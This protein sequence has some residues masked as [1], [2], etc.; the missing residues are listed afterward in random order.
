MNIKWLMFDADNTLLDFKKACDEGLRK[1]FEDFDD[2]CTPEIAVLY[3]KINAEVWHDFE[4]GMIDA[5][6]LRSLRFERLFEAIETRPADPYRF[7][8]RYLENLVFLSEPYD[9]LVAFL[10]ALKPN[11]RISLITNGLKE[12]QRPRLSRLG[13]NHHFDSIV[14]SDEIGVAK[15]DA[16][17]FEYAYRDIPHEIEKN[18]VMVVGDNIKADIGGGKDYGFKTCW[19]HHGKENLTEI[20]PDFMIHGIHEFD[21][22]LPSI[23]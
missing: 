6:E 21:R 11:Y 12:V 15:P 17:F 19:V 5:H 9:G 14:V 22:V 8:A 23:S 13:L 3:E 7:N 1:T 4:S 20:E 10:S 2:E 16:A 18:E